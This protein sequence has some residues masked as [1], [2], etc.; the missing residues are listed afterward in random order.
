[1][2]GWN[3][4]AGYSQFKAEDADNNKVNTDSPRKQFKLFTTYQFV[5]NYQRLQS[6]VVLTGKASHMRKAQHVM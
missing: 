4:S 6:V 5:N 1:M 3:I 2:D